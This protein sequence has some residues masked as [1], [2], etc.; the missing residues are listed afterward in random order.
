MTSLMVTAPAAPPDPPTWSEIPPIVEA[1]P[2]PP[3]PPPA[4]IATT[5][6]VP[7]RGAT[8]VPFT[9]NSRMS[10]GSFPPGGS[11]GITVVLDAVEAVVAPQEVRKTLPMTTRN[12][13]S[14]R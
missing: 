7:A 4:P 9:V 14:C 12:S 11:P 3:P 13:Q 5:V 6:K 10:E 2:A 1:D 8:H